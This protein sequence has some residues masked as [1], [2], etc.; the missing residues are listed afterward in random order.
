[1]VKT[2]HG[3]TECFTYVELTTGFDL[4]LD[5]WIFFGRRNDEIHGKKIVFFFVWI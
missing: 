4:V 5:V 3:T 2:I 1:M